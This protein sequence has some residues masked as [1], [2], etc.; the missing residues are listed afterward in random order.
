[1]GPAVAYAINWGYSCVS[2]LPLVLV[3]AVWVL[4]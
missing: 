1:M 4:T 3:L 2:G